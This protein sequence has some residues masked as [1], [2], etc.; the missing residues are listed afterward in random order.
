MWE[1]LK[2]KWGISSNG[3]MTIIFIV[4][5]ITGSASVWV[6]KPVMAQLGADTLPAY[7]RFPIGLLLIFP[8]Y[9]VL[10]ITIGTI[11]G[12]HTFFKVFLKRMWRIRDSK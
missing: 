3:Q 12:Q 2:Q 7:F 8:I 4:F 9:Q 5:A 10:L 6:R 11:A 1:R